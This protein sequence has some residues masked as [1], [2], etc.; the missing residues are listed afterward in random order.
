[1]GKDNRGRD[2]YKM[3]SRY[4]GWKAPH[5]FY[6][7]RKK[8][9]IEAIMGWIHEEWQFTPEQIASVT[10]GNKA[11]RLVTMKRMNK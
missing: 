3:P 10:N 7:D 6:V 1:M 5:R 8:N 2:V 11:K 9:T 4:D